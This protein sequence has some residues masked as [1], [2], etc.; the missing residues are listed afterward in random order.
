MRSGG[1]ELEA[2][3]HMS[4][5]CD[6]AS[7]RIA[8]MRHLDSVGLDHRVVVLVLYARPTGYQMESIESKSVLSA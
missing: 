5:V 4:R 6:Q 1:I 8:I 3:G 2:H 7:F